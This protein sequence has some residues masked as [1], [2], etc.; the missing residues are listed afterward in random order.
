MSNNNIHRLMALLIIAVF[1]IAYPHLAQAAGTASNTL[2]SNTATV[3]Y[4]VGG[5]AQ[6]AIGSSPAGNAS[7]AGTPTTF[8]VDN[9]VNLTVV[10]TDAGYVSV[11]S[12]STGGTGVNVMTFTVTNNGNTVQDYS[13]AVIQAGVTDVYNANAADNFDVPS[14]TIY[15]EN[16]AGCG[17]ETYT[18]GTDTATRIDELAADACRIVYVV[19]DIDAQAANNVA[20]IA[21]LATTRD[22]GTGGVEGAV[23]V[24]NSG[25]ADDPAA[26]DVV[27][28]DGTDANVPGDA[29]Q[30][31]EA[32]TRGAYRVVSVTLNVQK[33]SAVISD[34]FS[35]VNP[36]AIPGAIVEYTIT[37][38]KTAGTGTAASVVLSDAVPANTIAQE[39]VYAVTGEIE[40]TTVSNGG[41][42]STTNLQ[43]G[44]DADLTSWGTAATSPLAVQCGASLVIVNDYCRIK[45]RVMINPL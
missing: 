17:A 43:N 11:S 25:S 31:G 13:L 34:P 3:N 15:V 40:R 16:N 12:G 26:V 33:T 10:N 18:A 45:Y 1:A 4:S 14:Y 24:E 20:A 22:G 29:D 35:A 39:N 28:A 21:L 27:W 2:I 7:G 42:P 38:T 23:T 41:A 8:R 30:D 9:K 19:S 37:V 36:K 5:S 32:G 6:A 44:V